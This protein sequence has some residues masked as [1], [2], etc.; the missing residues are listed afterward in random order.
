MLLGME[1]RLGWQ[2]RS[3]WTPALW[4]HGG[5]ALLAGLLTQQSKLVLVAVG[6]SL[7][8]T[9]VGARLL[10]NF[11]RS[12]QLL[13][14]ANI[15]TTLYGL[16]W[17]IAFILLLP[18]STPTR[19]LM[20]VGYP[21]VLVT[22]PLG[23]IQNLE[24]WEVLLRKTWTR[25]RTSLPMVPRVRYPKVSVHV[26]AHRE[27]PSVVIATLDALARLEY[28]NFEVLVIDNNTPD[29][30]L[31]K[32]VKAHCAHLGERFR[33]FHVE[34]MTG[35]KAGALNFALSHTAPDV[36][37]VAV[38]DSDY[39][40]QPDFLAA[41][42]GHF[43]DPEIGFV[44]PPHD[45]RDWETSLYLRMCYWEYRLFFVTTMVT[46]NERNAGLTVGTMCII[47]RTALQEAGG[48]SEWCVTEDSELAI[49][50]HA[51]GYASVYLTTSFG[52][53]LIPETFRGY[54]RQRF[55][56]T[57]GPVQEFKHHLPLFLPRP[58]GQPSALSPLQ[59]LHHMNHGLAPF[60]SGI[61]TLFA[62]IGLA[63][64]CSMALHQEVVQLPL[65][66]WVVT[67]LLGVSGIGFTWLLYDV[68]VGCSWLD[69][70][71]A[72]VARQALGH[73]AMV[74]SLWGVFTER[75]PWQRTDKFKA[76]PVGLVALH[77]ARTELLLGLTLVGAAWAVGWNRAPSGLFLLLLLG[78]FFQ[79]LGYFAAPALALLA[80]RDIQAQQPTPS[81]NP[82]PVWVGLA[83]V[84][85][86]VGFYRLRPPT[87]TISNPQVLKQEQQV[88]RPDLL[89]PKLLEPPEEERD[90]AQ[91]KRDVPRPVAN[92]VRRVQTRHL[93]KVVA[94]KPLRIQPVEAP[95]AP[96]VPSPPLIVPPTP[97][98]FLAE[99]DSE[100][101]I[102]M[103][104]DC[105][106]PEFKRTDYR[107]RN[108][109]N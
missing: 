67:A 92:P 46:L 104:E 34:Q 85:L 64:L 96:P 27:P 88:A 20:L 43:D 68:A 76:L 70:I 56:W 15:Q 58:F 54:K 35:A 6:L 24:L 18:V 44:Q 93:L 72:M 52:R 3:W 22:L 89:E 50:I 26:P 5:A 65:V 40:A 86:L 106:D 81:F 98:T 8:G 39:L 87:P 51:L 71:G 63:V 94:K 19:L 13:L 91:E 107:C 48:W 62:P 100:Q 53:G 105:Y 33:F 79:G 77:S 17:G 25:P 66:L 14:I 16:F 61:G 59:K 32:P 75:I 102:P 47:R 10:K 9:G 38:V 83:T 108:R 42:V 97:D 60:L 1:H 73:T 7:V 21:L 11:R 80:E 37:L 101:T 4:V 55:R 82:R 23:L 69:M 49:R 57:Y 74:A 28:P 2:E 90:L 45:Y 29:P 103:A 36:E 109:K 95:P 41:L 12:G 84:G 99:A 30:A 78:V 31:W